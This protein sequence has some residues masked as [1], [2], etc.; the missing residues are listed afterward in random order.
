MGLGSQIAKR[1]NLEPEL[2][3]PRVLLTTLTLPAVVQQ[4]TTFLYADPEEN[5]PGNDVSVF[6]EVRI[7]TL[8][9]MGPS[10]DVVVEILD[11]QGNDIP[12]D[13]VIDGQ[14]ISIGGGPGGVQIIDEVPSDTLGGLGSSINALGSKPNGDT[15]GITTGGFLVEVDKTLGTID[16]FIGEVVDTDNPDAVGSDVTFSE[17]D[18][19]S[20]D[21][22]TGT[23]YAVAIGPTSFDGVGNILTTGEVLITIDTLTGEAEAAGMN[24]LGQADYSLSGVS[25]DGDNILTIVYSGQDGLGEPIFLAFDNGVGSID[26]VDEVENRFITISVVK[27]DIGSSVGIFTA[28]RATVDD[29][30]IVEGLMYDQFGRLFGLRHGDTSIDDGELVEVDLDAAVEDRFQTVVDFGD[31]PTGGDDPPPIF[32]TGMSF[33]DTNNVGYA[34]DPTSGTLYAINTE[35]VQDAGD[36]FVIVGGLADIYQMYIASST[37]DVYITVTH[38]T[39]DSNGIRVYSPTGGTSAFLFTDE[40]SADVFTPDDA[41]GVMIGTVAGWSPTTFFDDSEVAPDPGPTGAYPGGPI[42][43]G[44]IVAPE[45]DGSA[46]DIGRIQIGGGVFG[47]VQIHGSIDLFYAGFLGTNQF[48]VDGDLNN[49]AVNTQVGGVSESDNSWTLAGSSKYG[50]SGNSP[51]LD[52]HGNLGSV[53]SNGD[54]GLPILVHGASDAPQFPG[55][56]DII[57]EKYGRAYREIGR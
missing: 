13:L 50:G 7:G 25:G 16:R 49:L 54:W 32:L 3:E 21:P 36:G 26:D 46:Q 57:S 35:F 11:Y 4:E 27:S 5:E 44:I 33:D 28:P 40:D 39:I 10:K 1:S 34:T 52:V 56:Y 2:L 48:V 19:A 23:L 8:S 20:F 17:F 42:R 47:D 55:V 41:G 43:P 37:P 6:N 22:V 9:G 24:N 15:F 45:F 53:Y 14:T 31:Q 38:L 12:G 29:G 18:A 30:D 51:I